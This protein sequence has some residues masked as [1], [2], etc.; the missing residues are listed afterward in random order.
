MWEH[1][2]QSLRTGEDSAGCVW[3]QVVARTRS[4]SPQELPGDGVQALPP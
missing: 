3:Q 1:L 2:R 4:L